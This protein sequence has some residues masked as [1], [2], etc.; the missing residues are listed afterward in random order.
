MSQNLQSNT[1]QRLRE[2]E[3]IRARFTDRGQSIAEWARSH[4]VSPSAAYD[5]LYGRTSGCKGESRR[6]AELLTGGAA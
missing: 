3:A 5:Y 2:C 4:G 6:V 1:E